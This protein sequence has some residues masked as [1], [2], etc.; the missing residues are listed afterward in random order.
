MSKNILVIA[1]Y[2]GTVFRKKRELCIEL[3]DSSDGNV[4]L[5]AAPILDALGSKLRANDQLIA[6]YVLNR[7]D[8][9]RRMI[10]QKIKP[11][12]SEMRDILNDLR[13]WSSTK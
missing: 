11:D 2:T 10:Y 1:H 7:D 3:V 13:K 5:V 6:T 8:K 4:L 12:R 9:K